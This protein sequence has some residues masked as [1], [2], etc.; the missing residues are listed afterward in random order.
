MDYDAVLLVSFGGPQRTEAV[1]PF[2][3]N[4]L[5]GRYVP[6]NAERVGGAHARIPGALRD[7]AALVFTAHSIPLAMAAA[8]AYEEQLVETARGVAHLAAH[9]E[10]D[11]VWQSRSGSPTQPWLEPDI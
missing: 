5:R 7:A 1:L 8:C 2:L 4:R 9:E 6:A 10:G 3:K 11:L